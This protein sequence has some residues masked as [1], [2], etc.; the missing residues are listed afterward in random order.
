MTIGMKNMYKN[1]ATVRECTDFTISR[2]A[3][4]FQANDRLSKTET[5]SSRKERI[6]VSRSRALKTRRDKGLMKIYCPQ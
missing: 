5:G 1:V 4:N 6:R 3:K 2:F